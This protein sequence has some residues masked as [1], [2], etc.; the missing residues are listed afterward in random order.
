MRSFALGLALL[1]CSTAWAAT[2]SSTTTFTNIDDQINLDNGTTGW[3]W[4]TGSCAGGTK[5]HKYWMAQ[6]QTT[7]SL[8]GNSTEFYV[9][10]RQWSDVLFWY[11]LGTAY[12]ATAN[13]TTDFWVQVDKNSPT[14]AQAFEFD[15]FQF[16]TGSSPRE[17]MFGTQCDYGQGYVWDIWN[18]GTGQWIPLNGQNGL[19]LVPCDLVKQGPLTPNVWYHMT[20]NFHRTADQLEH[21]DSVTIV[22]YDSSMNV[23]SN[24]TVSLNLTEASGPLPSGWNDDLGVQFQMD[25]NGNAGV[26]SNPSTMSEHVDKVS[27]TAW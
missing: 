2:S 10:G 8:D 1:L 22:R 18:Q 27:L 23:T 6:N 4:C 17:Y 13:F 11:K 20:W 9:D 19:P 15:T 7:P 16:I 26:G 5:A 21:Y 25:L 24:V 12:D 14:I 3:G